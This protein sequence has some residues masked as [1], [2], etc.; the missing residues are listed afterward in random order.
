VYENVQRLDDLP[1]SV[2]DTVPVSTHTT[3]ADALR[4]TVDLAVAAE[5]LGYHRFWV[6][7]HHGSPGIASSCP[8]VLMGRLAGAT[9][10][11]RIGSGGVMLPNHRPL[12]VAEQFNMLE[13]LYPGRIDLG[14]GRGPGATPEAARALGFVPET[15]DRV[16]PRLLA[17]LQE[18]I[19]GSSNEIEVVPSVQNPPPV[20]L[21][22]STCYS[23]GLAGALGLPFAFAHHFGGRFTDQAL[24][25]YRS[26]FRPSSAI[27]RPSVILTAAVVCAES[28][29]EAELLAAPIG[30]SALR[31]RAG[32]RGLLPTP[33]EAI[34][35]RYSAEERRTAEKVLAS[36]IYG[37]QR[38]VREGITRL[39][40]GTDPDELMIFTNVG[41][42]AARKRSLE[43]VAHEV[44]RDRAL[45]KI[46]AR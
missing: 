1:L 18:L 29:K 17:E 45:R 20:W 41:D 39:I 37:D 30:L 3:P 7:E 8:P 46:A 11:L 43:L 40:H 31:L 15:I 6:A 14:I 28:D 2:L 36:L 24:D 25:L 9:R 23:A 4:A 33:E 26:T 27:S 21:L 44:Y 16:F 19:G 10:I 35:Y 32:R 22:G 42:P 12:V 38:T 13:A 34:A 5:R